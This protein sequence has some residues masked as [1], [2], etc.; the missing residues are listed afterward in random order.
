MDLLLY[1]GRTGSCACAKSCHLI[2]K[3]VCFDVAHF[4]L[5]EHNPSFG[6]H[7]AFDDV[8]GVWVGV[9]SSYKYGCGLT[10]DTKPK[11]ELQSITLI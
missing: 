7:S 6:L 8:T 5:S 10:V 9:V 1:A 11:A 2:F 4:L 3:V